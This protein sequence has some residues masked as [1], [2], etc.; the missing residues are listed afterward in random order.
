MQF[1]T[2]LHAHT[3][4]SSTC[5][6]LSASEVAE[7]YIEAGYTTVLVTN[8]Y[9]SHNLDLAGERWEDRIEHHLSGYRLMKEYA[10]DRLCVLLGTELRFTDCEND[11]LIIGLNEEF[12]LSHPDL[13][14]MHLKSFSELAH[15]NGLLIIQAHPFRNRMRIEH[16]QYL[17]G[18]EVFN[19]HV[20]HDS[21]N[22][23]AVAW[24]KKYGLLPTAGTD[25]HHPHQSPVAGII[26]DF[27]ITSEKE[28]VKVLKSRNYTLHC[29]GP[30]AERDGMQDMPANY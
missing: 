6:E 14:L 2:E 17:D 7:R 12:L 9:N 8:H 4:E 29:S 13:H 28:L 23:V 10:S 30:A 20:G 18:I 11:Y 16:P 5:G 1:K 21:R 24:A 15:E 25:F 22:D 3:R 26:T 19:G 27:P